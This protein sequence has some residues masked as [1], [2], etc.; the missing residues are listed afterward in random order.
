MAQRVARVT[1]CAARRFRH[2]A[3]EGDLLPSRSSFRDIGKIGHV[4]HQA[5][6]LSDFRVT[7]HQLPFV[8]SGREIKRIR[9][10]VVD[11]HQVGI[12][13]GQLS[14]PKRSTTVVHEVVACDGSSDRMGRL[15][16]AKLLEHQSIGNPRSRELPAN[17]GRRQ[18]ARWVQEQVIATDLHR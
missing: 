7:G 2:P 10:V 15:L 11:Q 1:V 8:F 14:K 13:H 18:R 4:G 17:S 9:R 12:D 5:I 6:V 3:V 16:G